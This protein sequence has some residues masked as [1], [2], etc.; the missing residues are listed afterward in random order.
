M[1]EQIEYEGGSEGGVL[2]Q[3]WQGWFPKEELKS[4]INVQKTY[5]GS[6]L[7]RRE[8]LKVDKVEV[9]SIMNMWS[10]LKTSFG[11]IPRESWRTAT[12][13]PTWLHVLAS[14]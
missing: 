7:R 12:H 10:Q 1:G 9:E 8:R 3:M 6:V 11:L 4:G 5:L 2:F 14:Q 13:P